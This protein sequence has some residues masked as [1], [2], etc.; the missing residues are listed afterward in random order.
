MQAEQRRLSIHPNNRYWADKE[1]VGIGCPFSMIIK[2][3]DNEPILTRITKDHCENCSPLKETCNLVDHPVYQWVANLLRLG[4]SAAQ[5]F[6][7]V[8]TPPLSGVVKIKN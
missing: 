2:K 8:S 4:H 1:I 5:I 7:W 6:E 3:S